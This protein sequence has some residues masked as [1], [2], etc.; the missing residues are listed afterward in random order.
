MIPK[1]LLDG[2]LKDLV[3]EAQFWEKGSTISALSSALYHLIFVLHLIEQTIN[4]EQK[5]KDGIIGSGTSEG[6][7]KR[8]ILTSHTNASLTTDL[9]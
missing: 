9:K 8:W 6:T 4:K 3:I 1:I 5:S 2:G 7:V